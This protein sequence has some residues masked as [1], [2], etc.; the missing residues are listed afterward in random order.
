MHRS[1]EYIPAATTKKKE[2]KASLQSNADRFSITI[3]TVDWSNDNP[4]LLSL[5]SSFS[6]SRFTWTIIPWTD[7]SRFSS[8]TLSTNYGNTKTQQMITRQTHTKKP[9]T[10]FEGCTSSSVMSAGS[11]TWRASTPTCVAVFTFIFM[12]TL[13][14]DRSPT[15]NSKNKIHTTVSTSRL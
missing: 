5:P 10:L 2:D 12:Y 7:E 13:E 9:Q 11:L 4:H 3:T 6:C 1:C 8:S 14:S 15:Y